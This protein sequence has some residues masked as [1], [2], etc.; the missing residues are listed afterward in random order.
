MGLKFLEKDERIPY[1]AETYEMYKRAGIGIEQDIYKRGNRPAVLVVDLQETFTSPDSP[2]GTKDIDKERRQAI[3]NAVENTKI[4]L[5]LMRKKSFPV[6]YITL[7]FREDGADGGR[8]GEK[9]PSLVEYCKRGSK[10]VNIDKRVAPQ[11]SDYIIEKK[12]LSG[13][14]GTPLLQILASNRV[15]TCIVTGVSVSG[16]VRQ[17]TMDAVSHGYYAV[18]PEECVS[19]RAIGPC[20][21]SLFDM[22]TKGADVASLDDILSWVDNLT[23][24]K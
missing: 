14:V 22:M 4:L 2:L 10:W 23:Q 5:D 13:F 3:N 9:S 17:T 18:V 6:I 12:T 11:A 8:W 15:D 1:I 24:P 20:K 7:V 21:A 19:D 16:C